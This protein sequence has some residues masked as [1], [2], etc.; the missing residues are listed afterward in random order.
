MLDQRGCGKSRP[1]ASTVNN[2]TWHLVSDIEALRE[3]LGIAKWHIVFG[4]SWGS[5]LA[6][7]YAQ[8]HPKSVG[9]L[10]LRG[11]FAVREFELKWTMVPGG[12]SILFPDHF[13]EFI[14][15]LPK[16]ERADHIASYHKRLMSDDE[17]ISHPAARAWNKWEVSI[18]TL[19]PN[20]K[21]LAQL[22]DASYNLAH[23]RTEA[24]Y[25]QN[26]AWLEEGQLL[27]KENID[28]IRHIPSE[29]F[30]WDVM[31]VDANDDRSDYRTRPL[32][33]GLPSYH[34]LGAAQGIP[35][36]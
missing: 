13:D 34:C 15:F 26:Q 12:A 35:G 2:T 29:L 16:E 24:H 32:R 4:G 1:N 25:F 7:A 20:V 8:T 33:C 9:S 5:T 11:I 3:H 36:I 14:N 31:F 22:D 27:T 6:L 19:Y 30:R 18:S 21:G 23:A 28:K 17:S 10:A